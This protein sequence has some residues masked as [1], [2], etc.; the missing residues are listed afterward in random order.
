[1]RVVMTVSNDAEGDSGTA[2]LRS[3]LTGLP[4]LRGRVD[5]LDPE[6]QDTA[7]EDT[8]GAATDALVAVLEPGG[9]AAVLAGAIVAWAQTR[10]SSH[11]ITVIRPDGTEITI[12]SRQA[13]SMTPDEVAD[14][15]DRLARPGVPAPSQ[16]G[17]SSTSPS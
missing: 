7:P 1:M 16:E 8:M 12:S 9:V 3:W 4:E 10:R 14:L 15:A 17:D 6:E 2:G 11:T 13:R 5:H